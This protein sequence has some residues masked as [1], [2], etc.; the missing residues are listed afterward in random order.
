MQSQLMVFMIPPKKFVVAG[1]FI[2]S[3]VIHQNGLSSLFR[4]INGILKQQAIEEERVDG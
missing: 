1:R 2:E 3:V 4:L